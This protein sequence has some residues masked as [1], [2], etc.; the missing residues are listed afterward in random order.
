LSVAKKD[1]DLVGISEVAEMLGGVTR[2]RADQLTRRGR[3]FPAPIAEL[4]AGRI[5]VRADVQAW[6]GKARRQG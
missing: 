2:Q 3:D 6:I 1:C 4:R 5:W